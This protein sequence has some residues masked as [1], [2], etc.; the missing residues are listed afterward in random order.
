M[1]HTLC[2]CGPHTLH[3]LIT[4]FVVVN[5]TICTVDY[6]LIVVDLM[7]CTCGSVTHCTFVSHTLYLQITHFVLVDHMLCNSGSLCTY[8][9][10][11]HFAV[12]GHMLY[13]CVLYS[14]HTCGL[15][16]L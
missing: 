5:H 15:H 3:F 11:T 6:M 8:G 12:L 14:F 2:S 9:S 1:D 16:V 7:L 10:L 13:T 4:Q